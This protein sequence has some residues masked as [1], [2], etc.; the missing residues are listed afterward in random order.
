MKIQ[1]PKFEAQFNGAFAWTNSILITK[2]KVSKTIFILNRHF[3]KWFYLKLYSVFVFSKKSLVER[4]P[5]SENSDDEWEIKDKAIMN[6]WGS[7]GQYI[8]LL[9][10][11][12]YGA[13]IGKA[14]EQNTNT[15]KKN[16][17]NNNN[18]NYNAHAML[19]MKKKRYVWSISIVKSN[20]FV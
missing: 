5:E 2:C 10:Q 7:Q 12:N 19:N 9:L 8:L 4:R 6:E 1:D 20:E 11:C 17:S 18:G 15:A 13:N 3:F 16:N 14:N